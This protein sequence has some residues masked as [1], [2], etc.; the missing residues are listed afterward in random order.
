[1]IMTENKRYKSPG[2]HAA[3]DEWEYVINKG[4]SE[5]ELRAELSSAK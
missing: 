3:A 4:D 1:M 5:E 2:H